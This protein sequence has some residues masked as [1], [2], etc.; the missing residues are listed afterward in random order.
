[1]P[2]D[3]LQDAA[4]DLINE[5]I[6]TFQVN[7]QTMAAAVHNGIATVTFATPMLDFAF[8]VDLLFAHTLSAGYSDAGGSFGPSGTALTEAAILFDFFNFLLAQEL[9]QLTQFQVA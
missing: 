1:M 8:L 4:G 7:G 5:G 3:V 6:V 9:A 2:T